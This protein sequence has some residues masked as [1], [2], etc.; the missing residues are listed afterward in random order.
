MLPVMLGQVLTDDGG[1]LPGTRGTPSLAFRLYIVNVVYG[2]ECKPGICES[3][4]AVQS[5]SLLPQHRP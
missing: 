5:S 2:T 4:K 1:I 3:D